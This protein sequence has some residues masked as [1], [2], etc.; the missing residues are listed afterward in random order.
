[1]L[2]TTVVWLSVSV[3]ILRVEVAADYLGKKKDKFGSLK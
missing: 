2:L 3:F 1:M